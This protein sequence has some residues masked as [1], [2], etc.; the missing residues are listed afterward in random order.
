MKALKAGFEVLP[1][2]EATD[3]MAVLMHIEK[4]GRSC[5]KSEDK[6]TPESC[7]KFISNLRDRKHWAMLEHY[8]FVL[9]VPQ[10]VFESITNPIFLT[11]ENA[12]LIQALRFIYPTHWPEAPTKDLQYIVSGSATA[13]NNL[14][15]CSL[16]QERRGEGIPQIG[17]FMQKEIPELMVNPYGMPANIGESQIRFLSRAEIES[18]PAGLRMLHDSMS[19]YFKVDRGVT[20][21]LV[22]HRP[23]SWAQ[24]S[25][26]YCNYSGGKFNNEIAVIDPLFWQGEEKSGF[27]AEWEDACQYAEKKYLR[28]IE[29]GASPQEARSVLPQSTKADIIMT[30][31]L[32]EF[33]HFFKMRLPK[34]A[35]P[36]MREVTIPAFQEIQ[37]NIQFIFDHLV[38][39]MEE[40]KS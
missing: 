35:H 12:D 33:R 14:W 32:M 15:A 26:R 37:P 4:I 17:R 9:S 28:L 38:E 19:I 34:T 22:R 25:T 23:A 10:S 29:M 2:P 18:L 40:G 24:E 20:H 11:G 31:P 6:I 21:E 16:F 8:Y 27:Y 7:I 30:A 3:R 13:F 39:W 1:L 5:Y 36:Q